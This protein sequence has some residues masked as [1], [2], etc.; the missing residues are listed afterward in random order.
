MKKKSN[1]PFRQLQL[2]VQ[3]ADGRR[4][5]CRRF[6][7]PHL[8]S[9]FAIAGPRGL[10]AQSRPSCTRRIYCASALR[11]R[12]T[13][14]RAGGHASNNARLERTAQR[15]ALYET[16]QRNAA[17]DHAVNT[18]AALIQNDQIHRIREG[19]HI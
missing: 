15:A 2:Y 18:K 16:E 6:V 8:A 14:A 17:V 11:L 1:F 3:Q 13:H 12:S 19:Q 7:R 9:H 4:G 5:R 10:H